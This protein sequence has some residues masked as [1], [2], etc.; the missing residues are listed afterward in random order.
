MVLTGGGPA[1]GRGF[2]RSFR[3]FRQ[4]YEGAAVR[5]LLLVIFVIGL[6]GQ[7]VR[8]VGDMLEGGVLLGG[9]LRAGVGDVLYD[10]L[11]ELIAAVQ[12]PSRVEASSRNLG[13]FTA[14]AFRSRRVEISFLG[15]T[16]ET[17]FN[18][19]YHRLESMAEDPGPTR[20]VTI[21]LIVPDFSVPMRVPAQVGEDGVSRDDPDFRRR[22]EQ[23]CQEYEEI[24]SNLAVE[25]TR[26]GRVEVHCEYRVLLGLPLH[27]LCIFNRKRVLHGLYGISSRMSLRGPEYYDPKGYDT[28]LTVLA[29]ER[30]PEDESAVRMWVQHFEDL[31]TIAAE[32]PSWRRSA[33]A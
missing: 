3:R 22:L 7:F 6:V 27:K 20:E 28:D 14:E 21:R 33:A 13:G 25:L 30:R 2:G 26:R 1:T 4:R 11:K 31:W 24:L 23:K 5:L 29:G 10:A 15:Y 17:V 12:L 32:V 8:P 9:S 19:L 18:E 16:G